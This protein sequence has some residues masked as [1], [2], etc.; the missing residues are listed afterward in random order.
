MKDAHRRTYMI[1]YCGIG[2]VWEEW[3]GTAGNSTLITIICSAK[4]I[5]MGDRRG[6]SLDARQWCWQLLPVTYDLDNTAHPAVGFGFP[7]GSLPS[8]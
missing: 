5:W 3:E 4:R 7:P 8:D 6:V 1:D 2:G